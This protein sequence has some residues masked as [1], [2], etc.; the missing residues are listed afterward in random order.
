MAAAAAALA[1]ANEEPTSASV[2]AVAEI[3]SGAATRNDIP[4][5]SDEFRANRLAPDRERTRP[6]R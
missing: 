4:W 6:S 3:A 1:W 2:V 5:S